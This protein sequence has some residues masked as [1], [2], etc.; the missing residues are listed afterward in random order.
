MSKKNHLDLTGAEFR[1]AGHALVD[2]IAEFLDQLP[3]LRVT[4]D[5]TPEFLRSL[6]EPAGVPEEGRGADEVLERAS[7]LM[8][9]HSLYNGHPRFFGYVNCSASPLGALGDLLASAINPNGSAF[10]VSP[11]GSEI[12]RQT[13]R[14]I[15][16]LIGYPADAGG[17]I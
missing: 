16:E 6:L 10:H 11:M 1:R 14:W 8:F 7:E 15:A 5:E 4:P 17:V 3:N 9:E 12:E 2:R 13:V